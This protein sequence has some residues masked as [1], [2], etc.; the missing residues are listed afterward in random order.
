[1]N[2][3]IKSILEFHKK[4]H[5]GV[6]LVKVTTTRWYEIPA[7]TSMSD[8]ELLQ[9]WFKNTPTTRSHAFRDGSLLV[10][11]FNNDEKVLEETL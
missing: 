6:K 7:G 3:K 9:D 11:Y 1:M 10:E 2:E 8:D 4:K 5:P